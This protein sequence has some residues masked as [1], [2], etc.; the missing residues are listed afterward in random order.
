MQGIGVNHWKVRHYE[1]KYRNSLTC[2]VTIAK[3]VGWKGLLRGLPI[4]MARDAPSFSLYMV[5]YEYLCRLSLRGEADRKD[6]NVLYAPFFGAF[7]GCLG[8]TVIYPLD[9]IK[10][11]FQARPSYVSYRQ[12]YF[13]HLELRGFRGFYDGLYACIVRSIFQTS[14]MFFTLELVRKVAQP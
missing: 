2:F 13:K 11:D 8:W 3:E 5:L 6:F 12:V 4:T 7:C 10:T 1:T 9:T 14:A